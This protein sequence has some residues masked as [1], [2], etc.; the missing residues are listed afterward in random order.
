MQANKSTTSNSIG[1]QMEHHSVI[2][3]FNVRITNLKEG[4]ALIK[5]KM[6][7]IESY[8]GTKRYIC[9]YPETYLT[10]CIND[11]NELSIQ[12]LLDAQ[13]F[14]SATAQ[15]ICKNVTNGHGQNPE[16]I[17]MVKFYKSY[18]GWML[19]QIANLQTTLNEILSL[20]IKE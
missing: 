6:P 5:R 20:P 12:S 11:D 2:Q 8:K 18:T 16:L 19:I 14:D 10:I 15:E 7:T 3:M 17:D 9:Y 4:I 1:M 13:K